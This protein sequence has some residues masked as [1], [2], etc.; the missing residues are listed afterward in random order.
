[1]GPTLTV[2]SEW[3]DIVRTG[4]TNLQTGSYCITTVSKMR[5]HKSVTFLSRNASGHVVY[6]R[7]V[8][9]WDTK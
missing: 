6:Y 4:T 1:M 2:R 5:S 3:I 9:V 7:K 8:I